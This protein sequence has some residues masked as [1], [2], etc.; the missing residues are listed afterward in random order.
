MYVFIIK[1]KATI[2]VGAAQY[3]LS[4]DQIILKKKQ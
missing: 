1:S 2:S 3:L 4:L